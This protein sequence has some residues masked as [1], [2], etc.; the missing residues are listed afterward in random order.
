VSLAWAEVSLAQG[1]GD[2]TL[3]VIDRLLADIP[4]AAREQ[5]IP[6]PLLV[7]GEALLLLGRLDESWDAL[8]AALD[9][10][11]QRHARPL[12]WRTLASLARA[13]TQAR[14]HDLAADYVAA[15]RETVAAIADTLDDDQR[16]AYLA[17][18]EAH[19]PRARA[20]TPRQ[21]AKRAWGGLTSRERD[22]ALEVAAGKTNREIAETLHVSEWTI[23]THVSNILSKL[24]FTSRVQVAGWFATR[25]DSP[26]P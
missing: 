14:E 7:R 13:A 18:A 24:R 22:V 9:G 1:D 16:A 19:L 25:A 6:W 11:R 15:A 2:R 8:L 17:N 20:T 21:A 4:G 12:Q 26:P 23:E 5:S 3:T 10:A